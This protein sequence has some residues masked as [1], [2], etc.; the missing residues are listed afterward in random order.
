MPERIQLDRYVNAWVVENVAQFRHRFQV[1]SPFRHVVIDDFFV[2]GF[3]AGL[4]QEFPAF[5]R[6]LAINEDGL[7]GRKAVHE[8]VST[9]GPTYR[10][11][12]TLVASRTFRQFVAKITGISDLLY[13]PDYYGG[14]THENLSGQD[15]DPHIDFNF[16]PVT[17][18]HRRLNLIL[19]LNAQ[20]ERS[21]G[22]ILDLHRDPH[23]PPERDEI[24][25]VEPLFNRCVIFETTE[26]SWHG[27]ERIDIPDSAAITSRKSFALYYY[28]DDRPP[29]QT[30]PPHSTIYVER[31]LPS[32]FK[33]GRTLTADDVEVLRGI[34][35]RRDQHMERLYR[36]ISEL[37]QRPGIGPRAPSDTDPAVTDS[38]ATALRR[39]VQEL[40]GQ[41]HRLRTSNSWRLTRPLRRLRRAVTC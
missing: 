6:S 2:P 9:I 23:V 31:H 4:L 32:R 10:R 17:G 19:F 35:A 3:A 21:W 12:D 37:S 13:D 41:L 26:H 7:I 14:G 20:W 27:F 40:T 8:T 16:H 22:G 15:L 18:S 24:S 38:D 39:E 28:T 25:R 11:L 29:E 33:V 34:L 36:Q 5:D 1:A 30:G